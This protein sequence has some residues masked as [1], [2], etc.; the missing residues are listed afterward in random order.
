MAC[1]CM[2][3]LLWWLLCDGTICGRL[4]A[5]DGSPLYED[6]AEVRSADRPCALDMCNTARSFTHESNTCVITR[7]AFLILG[8]IHLLSDIARSFAHESNAC[9]ITR[10]AFLI[11]GYIDPLSCI[12]PPTTLFSTIFGRGAGSW[13][14]TS[15]QEV[16]KSS[17]SSVR[18]DTLRWVWAHNR[19]RATTTSL[20]LFVY[21][22]SNSVHF[23]TILSE[24][25]ASL[26]EFIK[27]Y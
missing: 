22:L 26:R 23:S 3:I 24:R 10:W 19:P 27:Q 12:P 11:L 6:P 2:R 5:V 15:T 20:T 9:V 18:F 1:R 8:C 14:S 16:G 25:E 13:H 7:W 21:N 17:K 4:H